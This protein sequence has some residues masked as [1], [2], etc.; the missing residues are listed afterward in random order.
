MLTPIIMYGAE[1]W[2]LTMKD[3]SRVQAGE[4]KKLRTKVNKTKMDKIRNTA[5]REDIGIV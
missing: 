3:R 2:R 1:C 4:M 5:I